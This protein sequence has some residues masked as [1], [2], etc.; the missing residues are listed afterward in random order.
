MATTFRQHYSQMSRLEG[1]S[2]DDDVRGEV[3]DAR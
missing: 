2:F 1:S 3:A